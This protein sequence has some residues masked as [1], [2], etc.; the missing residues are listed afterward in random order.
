MTITYPNMFSFGLFSVISKIFVA[1]LEHVLLCFKRYST[2]TIIV[3]LVLNPIQDGVGAKSPLP[4]QF[5]PCNCCKRK[6]YLPKL[7]AFYF[8]FFCHTG[9]KF[10][11]HT[12]CQSK[13]IELEPRPQLKNFNFS[14]QILMK[15]RLYQLLS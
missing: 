4:Y 2:K 6:T 3:V 8:Q 10:Q 7:S 1:D 12:L 5:F 14:G 9:V 13:I 11:D 15:L